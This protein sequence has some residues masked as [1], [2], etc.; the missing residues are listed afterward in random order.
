[1]KKQQNDPRCSRRDLFR[2][3]G[4]TVGAGAVATSVRK[5][6]AFSLL[7]TAEAPAAERTVP[8]VCEVCFWNCGVVA[9][10]RG[11]RVLEVRGHPDYPNTKGRLCARGNA[12]PG[13]F[14][15]P[16]RLKYPMVRVGRRGEGKFERVG[17]P[18]AYR[19]IADAFRKIKAEHGP[20]AL[21]LFYHG[22]G[23]P[24][25]RTMM[26][27]LGTPNY[28]A[29]AYAQCKGPRDVGF[30]LTFG[31]TLP[32]P[33][34][35]DFEHTQCMVLFGSHLGE[36]AH[37]GQV[38]EFVRAR[39][40]GAKLVVLD[41]RLSTVASKA[42]VWLPVRP[43]SDTAVILAWINLLIRD[44]AYAK[45][46]V[47]K[48][49]LGFEELRAHVRAFT[50]DWAAAQAEVPV[51]AI[52]HAYR[53]MLAA[54]PAVLVHPGRHVTW[55]GE[56]DTQ[57]ARAQAILIALLGA[58]W[59]PGGVFRPSFPQVSEY[60]T[61][62]FREL[63]PNVD[64]AARRY[65]F[66]KECSTT[67]IRDATRTGKPYPIKG[68]YVHATNLLQCMPNVRETLEAIEQLEM[69]VVCDVIPSEIAAHADVLLPECTYLERYDDLALGAGKRPYVGLRQP[70]VQSP[71]D[72][73]PA[74]RIA[75]EL[76]T[77]LGLGDYFSF[78]TFEEYLEARLK[79]TGTTLETLKKK[80]I[81]FQPPANP[82]YLDPAHDFEWHTPS[83]KVELMSQQ[84]A[85]HGFAPLPVHSPE[86][87]PKPGWFRL[88]Y[89]RSPLHT[90]GRTQN[91]E[92][93]F[94]ID[95]TNCVWLNP[96]CAGALGVKPGDAVMVENDRGQL[97]GPLPLRV[98]DRVQKHT[99]YMV[100]GFGHRS[101]KLRL[102][103][104]SGGSDT[105]V[106]TNYAVDPITGSTG[107]R[108]QFVKIRPADPDA[109]V[110]PCATR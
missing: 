100:H 14:R 35:L 96:C 23:G 26:V 61:P 5:G 64:Q 62:D 56:A 18:L 104:C 7:R 29:P 109:E 87:V 4:S 102:A 19:T 60:P 22:K 55:Y 76:G 59:T 42:D 93:L 90:F 10:V 94:D 20:E 71:Y 47:D 65:P 53:L 44:E 72:T 43:G 15:D 91:N 95:P 103:C 69:L 107:M 51:E 39:R 24:M 49:C 106:I 75:K 85:D 25:L 97:T 40:R 3:V 86:P 78:D 27:A 63:P 2:A 54:R 101:S 83:H 17:W 73:R 45:S 1:M 37:N 74:W 11:N 13:F 16:D 66:A 9:H 58:W 57:R 99:V 6:H 70:A 82:P 21:A 12:G 79:G 77:E 8:T 28:A 46:F 89:G 52:L 68:W 41:P 48:H 31:E 67:G 98:T 80:G 108:V 34:P 105:D 32:S 88:L 38:Q 50:P 81:H 110:K 36:N 30:K 92:V 33:E 84:L